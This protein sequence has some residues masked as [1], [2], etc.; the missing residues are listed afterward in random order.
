MPGGT[1]TDYSR[2]VERGVT[3]A[4]EVS[5]YAAHRTISALQL[6]F[7][8]GCCAYSR[9]VAHLTM[10]SNGWYNN[11]VYS[12]NSGAGCDEACFCVLAASIKWKHAVPSHFARVEKLGGFSIL[13]TFFGT[14][15]ALC[16]LFR[17]ANQYT[18]QV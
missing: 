11:C 8:S 18:V 15:P 9:C 3:R 12:A 6:A 14:L 4:L 10:C 17:G 7:L 1:A 13:A 2:L 16:L 5:V